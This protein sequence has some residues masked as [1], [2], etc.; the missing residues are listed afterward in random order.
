MFKCEQSKGQIKLIGQLNFESVAQLLNQRRVSFDTA[1][2]ENGEI[3]VDLS[4]ISQFNSASLTLLLDWM[5]KAQQNELQI[6][7][8]SAPKQLMVI[9]QA[10]GIDHELPLTTARA[11]KTVE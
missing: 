1:H 10:Y 7:Y 8:H 2:S 9:A 6:K 4:E 3:A 11:V 5:K